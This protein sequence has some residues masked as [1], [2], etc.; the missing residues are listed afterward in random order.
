MSHEREKMLEGQLKES[1]ETCVELQEKLTRMNQEHAESQA[2]LE[3]KI[4]GFKLKMRARDT[5]KTATITYNPTTGVV[6]VTLEGRWSVSDFRVIH[7]PFVK[8]IKRDAAKKNAPIDKAFRESERAAEAALDAENKVKAENK[9]RGVAYTEMQE[10]AKR[11]NMG[12]ELN[13]V[14]E[15]KGVPQPKQFRKVKP[16]NNR[17]GTKK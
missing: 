15:R 6:G 3:S 10:T 14:L 12:A 2:V 9:E 13:A 1:T 4:E 7:G 16:N 5:E 11:L 8:Q 17:K